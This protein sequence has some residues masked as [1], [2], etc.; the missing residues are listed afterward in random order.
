INQPYII[1]FASAGKPWNSRTPHPGNNLFYQYLDMTAWSGWR[2]NLY[3]RILNRFSR[4]MK[5]MKKNQYLA[6]KAA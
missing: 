1:H 6:S 5:N 2:F 3:R 4:S